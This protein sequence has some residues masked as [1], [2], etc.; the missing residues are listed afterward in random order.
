MGMA[1]GM[2][3]EGLPADVEEAL[4]GVMERG[5]GSLTS[6]GPP[7]APRPA[8]HSST[9]PATSSSRLSKLNKNTPRKQGRVRNGSD[10]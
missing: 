9:S 5:R 8:R 10:L 7:T 3:S 1:D 6:P 2:A 4:D